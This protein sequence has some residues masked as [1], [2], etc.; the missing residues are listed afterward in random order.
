MKCEFTHTSIDDSFWAVS[1]LLDKKK[2]E[3][4]YAS[5]KQKDEMK[6]KSIFFFIVFKL[7]LGNL[8]DD[9]LMTTKSPEGKENVLSLFFF[10]FLCFRLAFI[11]LVRFSV[12]FFYL[13]LLI[14][15]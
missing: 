15:K 5:K 7:M 3:E 12:F 2:E 4:C 8:L 13:V 9:R 1:E 14:Y 11:N 10:F 6:G